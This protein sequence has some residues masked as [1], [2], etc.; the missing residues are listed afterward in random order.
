[1][2]KPDRNKRR[3]P[4]SV[5][6]ERSEPKSS[7]RLEKKALHALAKQGL[8]TLGKGKARAFKPVPSRKGVRVSKMVID[9]RD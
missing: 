9:G 3:V 1:M 8:L 6:A 2:G 4:G 7:R 5:R